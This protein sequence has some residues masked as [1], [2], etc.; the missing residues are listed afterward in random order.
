V[1]LELGLF[2]PEL[3]LCLGLS[4]HLLLLLL[5]VHLLILVHFLE[6]IFERSVVCWINQW[7]N[8]LRI[9]VGLRHGF[10]W[11]KRLTTS[12]NRTK[13]YLLGSEELD[14]LDWHLLARFGFV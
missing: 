9:V 13:Y 2:K 1:L 7:E 12:V 8:W 5:V 14:D 4:T 3:A 6:H 10:Q 11:L